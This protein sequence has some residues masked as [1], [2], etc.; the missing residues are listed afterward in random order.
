MGKEVKIGLAVI[1]ALLC[2]FGGV[3][4]LR[5]KGEQPANA[6]E[7][8]A[9]A[10]KEGRVKGK[11]KQAE[12]PGKKDKEGDGEQPASLADRFA[13]LGKPARGDRAEREQKTDRYGRPLEDEGLTTPTEG[14]PEEELASGEVPDLQNSAY[15]NRQADDRYSRYNDRD[16]AAAPDEA[17]GDVPDG[18]GAADDLAMPVD[19]F[20]QP[21]GGV[22]F[23]D[24]DPADESDDTDAADAADELG[25]PAFS[26]QHRPD[27]F[28][29]D[30]QD[31]ADDSDG[32][33]AVEQEE[34]GVTLAPVPA[35]D[36]E[37][38]AVANDRRRRRFDDDQ[39]VTRKS[40][41][42]ADETG[43]EADS[44]SDEYEVGPRRLRQP[45]DDS[46]TVEPNDNFWRISQKVYGTGAY[47]KAL[48]EHNRRQF[49]DRPLI[50]VGDVVSTP[51]VS[52]LQQ[53]YPELSPKERSV[54]A[55]RRNTA[56]I[57][58]PTRGGRTYTVSEGDTLFD[59]ARQ[60]LGKASRWAE[61]YELNRDQLG[62][63]FNYL[64]PGMQLVMPTRGDK[65]DPIA[66]RPSRDTYRR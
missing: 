5:L 22:S 42:D 60:E 53:N 58:T 17:V 35:G 47:F 50:N 48:E 11:K 38:P 66:T 37:G 29:G 49:G 52:V 30:E 31:P 25:A 6:L 18:E 45:Q 46:Y 15:G 44:G 54:S 55:E 57:S 14:E 59:I 4:A 39:P 40:S 65:T 9:A 13:K 27:R 43:E 34:P 51:P 23:S 7:K 64:S 3:L 26:M 41:L 33:G 19:R 21:T 2:V 1:G 56:L 62:E 28:A 8:V 20:A 24:A 36:D 32:P 16:D 63:D 61:I 12:K 10:E